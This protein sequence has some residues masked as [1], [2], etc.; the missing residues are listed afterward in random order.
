MKDQ[1][2]KFFQVGQCTKLDCKFSHHKTASAM[3]TSDLS[4]MNSK[5]SL[6]TQCP[7]YQSKGN[8]GC[9]YGTRCRFDHVKDSIARAHREK[10]NS[11]ENEVQKQATV[12]KTEQK[13]EQP[14][15][16]MNA[17]ACE[18]KPSRSSSSHATG[19]GLDANS[20]AKKFSEV[21]INE[22]GREREDAWANARHLRSVVESKAPPMSAQGAVVAVDDDDDD[23][24]YVDEFGNWVSFSN[25]EGEEMADF[26]AA[27]LPDDDDLLGMTSS[28]PFEDMDEFGF[29]SSG[30][31]DFGG[32]GSNN[33]S[34]GGTLRRSN[35]GMG[36]GY[37][38]FDNAGQW[39]SIDDPQGQAFLEQQYQMQQGT[40]HHHQQQQMRDVNAKFHP[41]ESIL[42]A[43][44]D[45]QRAFDA[46]IECS[47]CL[48]RVAD[49]T[50]PFSQRRFGL[51]DKCEH[52]FCLSCIRGWRDGGVQGKEAGANA[53]EHARMCPICRTN[54]FFITPS[55]HYPR[56]PAEKDEILRN[57]LTKMKLIPCKH[58]NNGR[59]PFGSSCFYKHDGEEIGVRKTT[60]V[61]DLGE[62]ELHIVKT[63]TLADYL[64]N[65]AQA[66]KTMG[67]R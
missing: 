16:A 35:S 46:S 31:D 50:R 32:G 60:R 59:C 40:Q 5:Q 65:S 52:A 63:P 66:R 22:D 47:I 55:A 53:T 44:Y 51:L 6:L 33:N 61:G 20:L 58:Y 41:E 3:E 4:S 17:K 10:T 49:E 29:V 42:D 15:S 9:K 34:G 8:S 1:P 11:S 43:Q 28:G 54:S 64:E 23:W 38:Y 30:G 39:V 62:E 56:T 25:Q 12:S 67:G 45:Q 27:Q 26:V 13:R 37:G 19:Q 24:G 7:F 21:G 36:G 48:E 14:R 2:C 57:Y 18:F